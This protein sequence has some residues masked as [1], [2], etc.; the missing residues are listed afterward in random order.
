MGYVS[1]TTNGV[2]A[3]MKVIHPTHK[4]YLVSDCGNVSHIKTNKN[5]KLRKDKDGYLRLN[6]FHNGKNTTLRVH[7]LVGECFIPNPDNLPTINH[8]DGNKENN[9]VENLEWMT[10]EENTSDM[11]N[12]IHK[13][14][15]PCNING[16]TYRSYREAERETGISRHL[17]SK[18]S[19]VQLQG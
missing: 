17:I 14:C 18:M 19:H 5:R 4:N 10:V 11:Y 2:T 16:V 6:V 1:R 15:I 8:I 12:R 3:R 9:R 13:R 7:T